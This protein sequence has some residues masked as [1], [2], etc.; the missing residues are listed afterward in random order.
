M[1]KI[2]K[3]N[4]LKIIAAAL[5]VGGIFFGFSKVEDIF[6]SYKAKS[7]KASWG[8]PSIQISEE[9][10]GEMPF[11]SKGS[12]EWQTS[13]LPNLVGLA[14]RAHNGWNGEYDYIAINPGE[15]EWQ[16]VGNEAAAAEVIAYAEANPYQALGGFGWLLYLLAGVAAVYYAGAKIRDYTTEIVEL[17]DQENADL[18]EALDKRDAAEA[19][20]ADAQSK[21]VQKTP[22]KPVVSEAPVETEDD[23][24]EESSEVDKAAAEI[25][26]AIAENSLK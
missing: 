7:T 4:L 3:S 20:H 13:V 12:G 1:K 2:L 5:L 23:S 17:T 26:A 18:Q 14:S 22:E 24:K 11:G 25:Q 16:Y 19:T 10:W 21:V 9:S 6:L 8:L 15:T